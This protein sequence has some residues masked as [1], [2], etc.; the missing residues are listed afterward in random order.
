MSDVIE[1]RGIESAHA[2][3]ML[4]WMLD[5]EIADHVGLRSAPTL[6]RT[7]EW[8]TKAQTLGTMRAWAI[9]LGGEHV[10]NVVLDLIDTYLQSARLSIYVG[11]PSARGRGVAAQSLHLALEK[12]FREEHLHRIWLTVHERNTRA[13]LLYTRAGFRLEGI[14]R[15]DFLLRGERI[16]SILM[17]LLSTEFAAK[18]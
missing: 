2:S 8:I 15:G 14:L 1:L 17:S 3:R 7:H 9:L 6:D 16:N 12:G 11:E 18:T 13:A 4:R 5:P 10:G